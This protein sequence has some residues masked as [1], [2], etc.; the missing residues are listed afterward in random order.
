MYFNSDSS[1]NQTI[2][3]SIQ[4]CYELFFNHKP[5][6]D[7]NLDINLNDYKIYSYLVRYG[8]ILRRTNSTHVNPVKDFIESNNDPIEGVIAGPII[9]R[10]SHGSLNKTDIF[11]KLNDFIPNTSLNELKSKMILSKNKNFNFQF[12]YDVYQPNKLFKKSQPGQ[13]I[14]RLASKLSLDKH[15]QKLVL[16]KLEDFVYLNEIQTQ[17]D[18]NVCNLFAFVNDANDVLFYSFR[19][20]L[21]LPFIVDHS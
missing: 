8:Y 21:N 11:R 12:L 17:N 6:P 14:F 15:N 13:P 2:P 9:E 4:Q 16:P 1:D 18:T 20:N 10:S 3:L 5:K 19:Q 7:D